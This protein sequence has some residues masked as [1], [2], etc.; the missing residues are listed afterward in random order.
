MEKIFFKVKFNN[1]R[2]VSGSTANEVLD[3]EEW[4]ECEAVLCLP[5][6]YTAEGEPTQLI[7]SCHG[8]GNTV[9]EEAGKH[10]GL[11]YAVECLHAGY[12]ALDIS[13]SAPHGLT[14]ACPEHIFALYKAYRYAIKHY[15]LTERVL[16]VGHSMGGATS[17]NFANTFPSLV[18]ALG[19]V[20]PCLSFRS[21]E[22]GDYVSRNPMDKKFED[23]YRY[24]NAVAKYYR[25]PT[26]EFS[27]KNTTGF[28]PYRTR[29]IVNTE[30]ER[31][32]FPPCPIKIWQGASDKTID[33]ILTREYY[34][35]IR[36]AGCF[37]EFHLLD[38]VAHNVVD[39]TKK[40]LLMWFER[41]V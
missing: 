37:A 25:F 15:N 6:S 31:L 33:P 36:R 11:G 27:E 38:G 19:V 21:V 5:D 18:I 30:G 10:G 8:A 9:S 28:E 17:I 34:D 7:L 41:F 29:A 4:S 35:S 26:E 32:V 24:R 39:T 1:F 16:V 20:N 14:M 3:R 22:I 13:G 23:G 12:A 2:E 40:E